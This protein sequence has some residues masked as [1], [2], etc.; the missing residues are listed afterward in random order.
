M[1]LD[2]SYLF[3]K[4]FHAFVLSKEKRRALKGQL[5]AYKITTIVDGKKQ[6]RPRFKEL[7]GYNV[8]RENSG[9]NNKIFVHTPLNR[10]H[11][12]V[13]MSGSNN[14]LTIGGGFQGGMNVWFNEG[15]GSVTIG[16]NC[17]FANAAFFP[18]SFKMEV[19]DDVMMS[20]EIEV[21][22]HDQHV[23]LD[24]KTKQVL[25]QKMNVTRIGSHCW[26]GAR[27]T[28]LK[29]ADIPDHTII[30]ACSVVTKPFTEEYTA[31]GGNP[32]K[33]IKHDIMFSRESVNRY[34]ES[35]KG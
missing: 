13:L 8:I 12:E 26:L 4:Y 9:K 25:N 27:A 29:N 16:Q 2:C 22:G 33:V 10:T 7:K 15:N 14:T 35:K 24:A 21:W 19:G 23:L 11:V 20:R 17:I 32:A 31:L 1:S 30:G 18:S 5:E 28:I 34:L 3:A 6:R